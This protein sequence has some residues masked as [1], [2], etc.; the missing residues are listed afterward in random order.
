MKDGETTTCC[1]K[2]FVVSCH[3]PARRLGSRSHLHDNVSRL[4]SIDVCIVFFVSAV[5]AGA[6]G[7]LDISCV[8]FQNLSACQLTNSNATRSTC[9]DAQ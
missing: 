6:C 2:H 8:D 5:D 7:L 1:Y 4:S 9:S 3:P